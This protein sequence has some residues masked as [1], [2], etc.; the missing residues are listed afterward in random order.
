MEPRETA[1]ET[2]QERLSAILAQVCDGC[3]KWPL[4]T[5]GDSLDAHC[6]ACPLAAVIDLFGE[7]GRLEPCEST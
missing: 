3:C 2:A 7:T 1:Q 5:S 6:D 4:M